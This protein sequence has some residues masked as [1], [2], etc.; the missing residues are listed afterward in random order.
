VILC[1]F[2]DDSGGRFPGAL[3]QYFVAAE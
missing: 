2:V 1:R 3:K